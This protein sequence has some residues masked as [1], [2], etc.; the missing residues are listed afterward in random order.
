MRP[1]RVL[2]ITRRDLGI[3]FAGRRWWSLPLVS[4]LL[5]IPIATS[6]PPP[7]MRADNVDRV[8]GELPEG[9]LDDPR[10][11]VPTKP[12]VRTVRFQAPPEGADR[13]WVL[14][15]QTVPLR[16]REAMDAKDTQVAVHII[17]PTPIPLPQRSLLLSL[18]AAST[19]TGALSQTIPGERSEGTLETLLAAAVSPL[20]VVV[21]KWLAWGGYGALAGM[22]AVLA[23]VF[24]GHQDP[25]W[26]MLAVPW[27]ALGTVAAGMWFVRLADDVVGGATVAL[28]MLPAV[29]AT[30]G[31]L[32]VW[33]N[34]Y[35]PWLAASI[36]LGGVLLGAGAMWDALPIVLWSVAV[37]AGVSLALLASTARDLADPS[38]MRVGG[39]VPKALLDGSLALIVWWTSVLG[40]LMWTYGGSPER[41]ES[42]APLSGVTGG[43]L[44]LAV[45]VSLRLAR[46]RNI[47]SALGA[48]RTDARAWGAAALGAVAVACLLPADNLAHTRLPA[49]GLA[50]DAAER[51]YAALTPG[52]SSTPLLF[53]GVVVLQE[54]LFRGWLR[55]DGGQLL[56]IALFALVF[57]PQDPARG[58]AIAAVLGAVAHVG[59]G[60]VLPAIAAHLLAGALVGLLALQGAMAWALLAACGLALAALVATTA[61]R[62]P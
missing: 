60:S 6:P 41:T 2:A 1:G 48:W 4:G 18:V 19:L 58:A 52:W 14:A 25:G 31:L 33:V 5:L 16:V 10:I 7:D 24:A 43:L 22:L 56:Q 62:S 13:P 35:S 21:G 46:E 9:L 61:R 53:A 23:T 30:T 17:T 38:P 11:V 49:E 12:N 36:P 57:S 59:G 32:A 15:A 47:P 54:L 55:R 44:G 37:T 8:T 40:P 26:W 45:L 51:L 42:I 34:S 29:L 27:V 20:E 28:R 50:A 3:E 39:G